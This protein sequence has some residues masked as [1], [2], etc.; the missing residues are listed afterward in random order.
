MSEI[1]RLAVFCGSNP[2][3]RPEYVEAARSFGRLLCA[4]GIGIVYGGSSVGLMAAL[5]DTMLDDL[6]DIIGV[7]PRMLVDREVANKALTDLRIV[8]SM[9]ERKAMMAELADGFVALPGGIGT[10]EEFFEIWTWGQLGMH[11][12]P[13][14]LLNVAG[15]FDPLLQ[16]LDRAVEEKFVRQ[17]H[18]NMVVVESD[19]SALL[20]RFE[21]YEPPRVVKWINAGTI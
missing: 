11:Q 8:G 5:A 17:V 1:R 6:G 14:G 3:A 7:I 4:R 13:C 16:F 21:A 19:P 12:K 15:Y 18:R 2:G 9:H 10:L 20:A